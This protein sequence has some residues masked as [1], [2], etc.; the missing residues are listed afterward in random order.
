MGLRWGGSRSAAGPTPG[1]DDSYPIIWGYLQVPKI[2]GTGFFYPV[3][4]F[5]IY[6]LTDQVCHAAPISTRLKKN[7][8]MGGGISYS[9]CNRTYLRTTGSSIIKMSST[10]GN[11]GPQIG[12]SSS[13]KIGIS[14]SRSTSASTVSWYIAR[15]VTA[16]TAR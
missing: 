1:R 8:A 11:G 10:Y 6:H 5:I 7:P 13:S 16:L 2:Q 15:P 12:I 3:I 9:V 4:T 14:S